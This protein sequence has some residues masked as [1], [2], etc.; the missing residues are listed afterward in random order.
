MTPCEPHRG[1]CCQTDVFFLLTWRQHRYA[2]RLMSTCGPVVCPEG[3]AG[4][5]IPDHLVGNGPNST[6]SSTPPQVVRLLPNQVDTAPP[7]WYS[8]LWEQT[9][10]RFQIQC[11]AVIIVPTHT[12]ILHEGVLIIHQVI[13]LLRSNSPRQRRQLWSQTFAFITL[14]MCNYVT[15]SHTER[16]L[17]KDYLKD[18]HEWDL[19]VCVLIPRPILCFIQWS[20][21]LPQRPLQPGISGCHEQLTPPAARGCVTPPTPTP[22]NLVGFTQTKMS[23]HELKHVKGSVLIHSLLRFYF[24]HIQYLQSW[25]DY[26]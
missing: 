1:L 24:I 26:I 21:C 5:W 14:T 22:P 25:T 23:L 2:G 8:C 16:V 7:A 19:T 3:G 9:S 12:K 18:W 11:C 17:F 13:Y 4:L 20:C 15:Q 6:V 10:F